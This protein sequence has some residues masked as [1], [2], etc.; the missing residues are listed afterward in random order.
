VRAA[1]EDG[2]L[3]VKYLPY[4]WELNGSISARGTR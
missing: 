1:L 4:D 3:R 2:R